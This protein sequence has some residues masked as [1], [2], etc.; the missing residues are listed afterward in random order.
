MLKM[1]IVPFPQIISDSNTPF[2]RLSPKDSQIPVELPE[3]IDLHDRIR[4][5][6][7]LEY[8]KSYLEYGNFRIEF[9]DS[10]LNGDTLRARVTIRRKVD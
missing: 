1:T 7:G 5:V 2:K 8:P 6:D 9:E 10:I 4:M 3:L